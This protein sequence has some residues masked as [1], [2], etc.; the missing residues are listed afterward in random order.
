MSKA[1]RTDM[2]K[3]VVPEPFNSLIP[4]PDYKAETAFSDGEV[5]V[6]YGRSKAEAEKNSRKTATSHY[7]S[8]K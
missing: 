4:G 5:R 8:R 7:K 3:P 1:I 2:A 6:G